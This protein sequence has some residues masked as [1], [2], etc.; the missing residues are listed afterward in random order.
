MIE[1]KLYHFIIIIIKKLCFYHTYYN[2][3]VS[4]LETTYIMGYRYI[5]DT[6]NETIINRLP[7][8]DDQPFIS[9]AEDRL[10]K[11]L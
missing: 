7:I 9:I 3:N 11:K 10:N 6:I 8:D 1:Q 2:K 4:P 5:V